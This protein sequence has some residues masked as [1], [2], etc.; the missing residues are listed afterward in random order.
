MKSLVI[1]Y[2]FSQNTKFI[3]ETIAK[4]IGADLIELRLIKDIQDK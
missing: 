3:A 2:S 4:N 1:F